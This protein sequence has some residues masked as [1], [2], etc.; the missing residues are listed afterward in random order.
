MKKRKIKWQITLFVIIIVLIFLIG[1]AQVRLA[2]WQNIKPVARVF[3]LS[4][5]SISDYWLSLKSINLLAKENNELKKN[6]IE[7]LNQKNELENLRFENKKLSEILDFKSRRTDLEIKTGQV[8]GRPSFGSLNQITIDLGKADGI[9]EENLVTCDGFLVGVIK[10]IGDRSSFVG[11][12]SGNDVKV[13]VIMQNTRSLGVMTGGNSGI[14]V[15]NIPRDS[16][17][18]IGELITTAGV[19]PNTKPGV[20]IGEVQK[21][22]SQE[23]DIFQSVLVK[24]PINFNKLEIINVIL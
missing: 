12:I 16:K 22:L 10:E 2:L 9:R 17:P 11:L 21:I 20:A 14:I 3:V 24:S 19:T 6:N 18:V 5:Q 13:A 1:I 4:N 15:E 7:L 23:N 8:I